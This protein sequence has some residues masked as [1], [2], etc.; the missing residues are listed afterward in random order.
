MCKPVNAT[1]PTGSFG[2]WTVTTFKD[3]L[4]STLK[5]DGAG[6]GGKLRFYFYAVTLRGWSELR[7]A[8]RAWLE[9]DDGRTANA[10]VGTDH[11]ITDPEGLEAMAGDGVV[12][13]LM[14]NYR[15]VFHPK[16]V[17]LERS[18]E[19]CVW[20]GSNNITRD[21]LINNIEFAISIRSADTPRAL[22]RWAK[23]VESASV[24]LTAGCLQSYRVQ[25]A[26]FEERRMRAN[27]TAFTW[28]ERGDSFF[29][30]DLAVRAGDLVLEVMPRETGS[31]GKQI[32]VPMEVAR[33]FFGVDVTKEITLIE[34][35]SLGSMRQL[36]MTVFPNRTA[37]LVIRE[38]E[39]R[40]RPCVIVFRRIGSDPDYEFEIVRES[41]V[42]WQYRRLIVEHCVRQTHAESRRWGIVKENGDEA[43]L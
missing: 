25:R 17:W 3:S 29:D 40:D 16:V 2:N 39:Y 12:V 43:A 20:A 24:E 30:S 36:T 27:A 9:F 37:R 22:R 28:R 34:R 11:A 41:I 32:Q 42:P 33:D 8:V 31:D 14:Q 35:G 7:N 6:A 38:L 18:R 13:R 4:I 19:S 10:Y 5:G 26:D 1:L 23:A 21:G 15:G